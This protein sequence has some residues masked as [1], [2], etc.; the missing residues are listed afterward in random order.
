MQRKSSPFSG[1]FEVIRQMEGDGGA[2]IGRHESGAIRV[3]LR[4]L[5]AIQSNAPE[6]QALA[7]EAHALTDDDFEERVRELFK[8]K[9][10][11]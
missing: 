7:D 2:F 9:G 11:K 3:G 1:K 5:A 10:A 4:S 8:P 6:F